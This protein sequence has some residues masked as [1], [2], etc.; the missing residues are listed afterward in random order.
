[1]QSF[2]KFFARFVGVLVATLGGVAAVFG[3]VSSW[4]WGA[5]FALWSICV[6]AFASAFAYETWR[7]YYSKERM[8]ALRYAQVSR[9]VDD[10]CR[11]IAL[12][13]ANCRPDD[14]PQACTARIIEDCLSQMMLVWRQYAGDTE[15][16][17]KEVSIQIKGP[18]GD[19]KLKVLFDCHD[20]VPLNR[21]DEPQHWNAEGTITKKVFDT[22]KHVI[23]EDLERSEYLANLRTQ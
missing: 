21:R 9:F 3:Q 19:G 20:A 23:V 8:D 14:S 11:R 17:G 10:L 22:K 6:I 18:T 1:M 7:I 13:T 16:T 15:N 2:L 4:H 5:Q 12:S